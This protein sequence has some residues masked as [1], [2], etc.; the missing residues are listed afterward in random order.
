M[1][2]RWG[3]AG[4]L[5]FW[6]LQ[7]HCRWWLQPWNLKTLAFRKKSYDQARQHI[8]KQ[9]HYFANRGPFS[10]SYGF[11]SSHVWIWELDFKESWVLKNWCFLT[12]V[13]EKTLESPLDCKEIQLVHYKE[14][15]SWIF[16][17]G[18]DAE[19]E[20]PILCPPDEKNW[21]IGKDPDAGKVW[22]QEEKGTIEDEM[23]GWQHWLSAHE[24]E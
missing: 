15:Q 11:S 13:L 16:I 21:L 14:K 2:N 22:R 5:Y 9:R 6:G 1:T 8:K 18:T 19:A 4:R 17:G 7:N 24:F 12:V 3:I 10:Q 20:T 23:V